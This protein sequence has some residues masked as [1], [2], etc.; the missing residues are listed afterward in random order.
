MRYS[1]IFIIFLLLGAPAG[2]EAEDI[3]SVS[4]GQS[5]SALSFWSPPSYNLATSMVGRGLN[6]TSYGG[7]VL[8]GRVVVGVSLE[9]VR[10]RNGR[11]RDLRL[12]RT[13]FPGMYT[14]G[15]EPEDQKIVGT[16]FTGML[17]DGD[18]IPLRV[19][20]VEK[21]EDGSV[22]HLEYEV[23]YPADGQWVPLCGIDWSGEPVHSIPLRG[24]WNYA[25]GVEGGGGHVEDD[26]SFTFACQ[27]HVLA[28]CVEM[29]YPPWVHG[30][31]CSD[32][33]NGRGRGRGCR[34]ISL[35]DHHQACTRLL[36]ADYC[37][38]G[39]SFTTAGVVINAYDGLG[40]RVD[41]EEWDFEAEWTPDG[42]R[43]M[44][45][46]RSDSLDDAP[47]CLGYLEAEGCGDP[48]HFE[49]GSALL[50]SELPPE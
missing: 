35:A 15:R 49:D 31:A 46:S 28:K 38:D 50:M 8:D 23:S 3:H 48:E 20:G 12:R 4:Y 18:A 29:G 11:I 16:V 1:N 19:D 17:D 13:V 25:E 43:C 27:G 45:A 32:E 36:R 30:W 24:V 42:A 6:G 41:S 37:G 44:T 21:V 10:L 2:C 34:R 22:E 5:T 9:N 40:I 7:K 26:S 39:R 47:T 33:E 14:P